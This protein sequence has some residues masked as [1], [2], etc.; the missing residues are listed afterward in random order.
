MYDA[1][2]QELDLKEIIRKAS[3]LLKRRYKKKIWN[4]TCYAYIEIGY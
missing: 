4:E 3:N 1:G 2:I